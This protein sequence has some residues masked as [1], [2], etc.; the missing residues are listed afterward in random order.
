MS[1]S[2]K[3]L[4]QTVQTIQKRVSKTKGRKNSNET[5]QKMSKARKKYLETH[6]VWNKG[7]K[8]FKQLNKKE[9]EH[10]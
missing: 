3:G 10:D 4:K 5:K 1:E 6:Q 9:D 2:H 7:L 8:N